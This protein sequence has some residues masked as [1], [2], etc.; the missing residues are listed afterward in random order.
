MTTQHPLLPRPAT[1]AA[2]EEGPAPGKMRKVA[3]ADVRSQLPAE[4]PVVTPAER[5]ALIRQR[6]MR[7]QQRLLW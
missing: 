1:A 6:R 2:E 7:L 3:L 4:T 5:D